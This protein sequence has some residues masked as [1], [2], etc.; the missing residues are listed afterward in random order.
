MWR[1]EL[2]SASAW[3]KPHE[4]IPKH[5]SAF[6]GMVVKFIS[7]YGAWLATRRKPHVMQGSNM[8]TSLPTAPAAVEPPRLTPPHLTPR[9]LECLHWTLLGKTAWE[10]GRI[11]GICD[12]VTA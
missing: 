5:C 1:F 9:E 6:R 10:T 7:S 11:L 12:K 4:H 2:N 8:N 3:W